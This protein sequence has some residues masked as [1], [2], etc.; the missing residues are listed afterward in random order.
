MEQGLK[1]TRAGMPGTTSVSRDPD[2]GLTLSET[3]GF[4]E[5]GFSERFMP[6]LA[7]H[8]ESFGTNCRATRVLLDM[9]AVIC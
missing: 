2:P 4:E 6:K 7:A 9:P 3:Y 5:A 8:Q 1:T